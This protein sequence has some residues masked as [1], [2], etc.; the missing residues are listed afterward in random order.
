MGSDP[1]GLRPSTQC[2]FVARTAIDHTPDNDPDITK[3]AMPSRPPY[4]GGHVCDPLGCDPLETRCRPARI[5]VDESPRPRMGTKGVIHATPL[6]CDPLKCDPLGLR[7]SWAATLDAVRVRRADRDRSHPG[8]RPRH[9]QARDAVTTSLPWGS[10]M[11]P[12]WVATLL[13]AT[14]LGCD[15]LGLRP[16]TQCVLISQTAIEHISDNDPDITKHALPSRPP[17]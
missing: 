7:P 3:H 14:P 11:R 6:G 2:V 16:S 8:H 10:Y 4:S 17:R 15:P 1:L 12:P 13:G 5:L 9:H